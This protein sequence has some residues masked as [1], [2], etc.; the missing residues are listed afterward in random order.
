M[1]TNVRFGR[2]LT[3]LAAG[4]AAIGGAATAE[5]T[6]YPGAG[7][8]RTYSRAGHGVV[9]ITYQHSHTDGL[10]TNAG[11]TP[12]G[13]TD[14]H[15]IEFDIDFNVTDRLSV[16]AGIPYIIK[17]H[18]GTAIHDPALLIPPRD[19]EF[20]DDGD[21]HSGFQDAHFGARY[22]LVDED[23]KVEP[24]VAVSF[25]VSDYPFFGAAA[26]GQQLTHYEFGS[27]FAYQPPLDLYFASITASRVIVERT[28]GFD[29][30]HWRVNLDVGYLVLPNVA[31][32][33]LLLV[34]QGGGLEAPDDFPSRTDELWFNHDRL[35]QHNYINAGGA[36][37]WAIDDKLTLTG[38]FLKQIH[39]DNIFAL[40]YAFS[41]TV[42]RAF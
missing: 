37:D 26:I 7:A 28:L 20:I 24:F 21:Y 36:I 27:R 19:S 3:G 8:A 12:V 38:S 10:F 6:Y 18:T 17:R 4:L 11:F 1:M 5:Q 42:S 39:R 31:V 16:T 22:L 2:A 40:K 23:F 41:L 30:D 33:G 25:P 9:A 15:A 29:I 34:K 13:A 32:R 14:T 35:L